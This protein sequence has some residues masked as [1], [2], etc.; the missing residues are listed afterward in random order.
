MKRK[1][2]VAMCTYNGALFVREQ[3]DSILAQEYLPDELVVCDD[4]SEDDTL[5]ILN[6]FAAIAPFEVRV[7]VNKRNLGFIQNFENCLLLCTGDII[8]LADQDDIWEKDKVRVIVDYFERNTDSDVVFTNASIINDASVVLET[9]DLWDRISF[10]GKE[11]SLKMVEHMLIKGCIV[12]GATMAFRK[13]I[14][15]EQLPF[16]DTSLFLHDALIANKAALYD[17]LGY[18]NKYLT[19]YRL[20]TAQAAGIKKEEKEDVLQ[21]GQKMINQA[22]TPERRIVEDKIAYWHY[23]LNY[24][25]QR[26]GVQ[27]STRRWLQRGLNHFIRRSEIIKMRPP[28]AVFRALRE[29]LG[30]NYQ[31]SADGYSTQIKYFIKD[32]LSD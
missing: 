22:W 5:L 20:H 25:Q 1:I 3:L 24:A 11:Q 2:S 4:C 26:Q 8:F 14:L 23:L 29:L 18:I 31:F 17:G 6:R 28:L 9:G 7:V 21:A 19:R 12:T 15:Q 10:S 13:E 30:G 32:I 27:E 16:F